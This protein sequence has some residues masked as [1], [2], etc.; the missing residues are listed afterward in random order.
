MYM[1]VSNVQ[2]HLYTTR[3]HL[4][5]TRTKIHVLSPWYYMYILRDNTEVLHTCTCTWT[6]C[7]I[8]A[9]ITTCPAHVKLSSSKL[10]VHGCHHGHTAF[11][12]EKCTVPCTATRYNK[13]VRQIPLPI[14]TFHLLPNSFTT[15]PTP[16]RGGKKYILTGDSHSPG[17]WMREDGIHW[18][19]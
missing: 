7:S 18:Q 10:L 3:V 6:T 5:T 13:P 16:K 12:S 15:P 1:Y 14:Y 4:Y 19:M 11:Y 9:Y 2:V 17:I 8:C